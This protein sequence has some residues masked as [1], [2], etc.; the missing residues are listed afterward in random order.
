MDRTGK[1]RNAS[2]PP[3]RGRDLST[4]QGS[5][6]REVPAPLKMARLDWVDETD[7]S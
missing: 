5:S 2:L 1:F 4:P 7:N 6:L 3:E